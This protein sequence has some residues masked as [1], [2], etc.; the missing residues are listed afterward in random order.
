MRW[1]PLWCWSQPQSDEAG[2]V[3][4]EVYPVD[5]EERGAVEANERAEEMDELGD[6]ERAVLRRRRP[7]VRREVVVNGWKR[8]DR[9]LTLEYDGLR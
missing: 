7:V 4:A 8:E 9:M 6:G 3:A 5:G 1:R 2:E